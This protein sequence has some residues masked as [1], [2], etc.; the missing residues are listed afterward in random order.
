MRPMVAHHHT[1]CHTDC[2]HTQ[3]SIGDVHSVRSIIIHS[4]M[5][6][7]GDKLSGDVLHGVV[8]INV[9]IVIL[10]EKRKNE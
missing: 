8:G 9:T 7:T 4:S 2:T 10:K 3:T 1:D 6:I 5:G